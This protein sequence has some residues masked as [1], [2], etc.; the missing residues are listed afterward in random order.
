MA[1]I[2]ITLNQEEIL[3]LMSNDREGAFKKLLQDSLNTVLKAESTEQLN[4][5]PYERS[6]DRTD[7]RNGSRQ[8]RLNTRIGS[9]TLEVPRHRNVPFKTMIFD[10]YKRSE[11]ALITT[12]AEMVVSGVSTRKVSNVVEELCGTSFSKSTVSEVCKELDASIEEFRQRP[13]TEEYPFVI[14]DATYFKVRDDHRIVSKALMIA[15]GI[16]NTGMR[17]V[18]G[19]QTFDRESKQTWFAFFENL[20]ARGLK[21]VRMITSDAH[22]GI[23]N[24]IVKVFPGVPWQRCQ[25]HFSKNIM[26]TVPAKYQKGLQSELQEMFQSKTIQEARQKKDAILSDYYDVAEKAM[27]CL[28]CGFEDAMTVMV[29]PERLRRVFRTSN[30]IERLNGELKRRSKVIGIFPNEGSILRLMGAV[31]IEQHEHYQ[32]MNRI[33]FNPDYTEMLNNSNK[34]EIIALEQLKLLEAA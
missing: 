7:S 2:N 25:Y 28:D 3:L 1:Q 12:M 8:R 17:E 14:V 22:E 13:L 21:G 16:T 18:L 9:I 11:S 27:D 5:A 34:L 19:F 26:S 29:I 15:I 31:L 6:S 23:I 10:S 4:A 24:A 20:K 32:T 30:Y 33:F